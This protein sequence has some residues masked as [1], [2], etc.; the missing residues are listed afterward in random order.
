MVERITDSE[1]GKRVINVVCTSLSLK[2]ESVV[3]ITENS[4]LVDDLGA[5]SLDVVE[6]VMAFET[7]FSIE[8]SDEDAQKIET[9]GDAV[10][11][12]TAKVEA[13]SQA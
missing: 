10:R 8:I 9:I 13:M 6:M 7:E 3:S 4:K 12:V 2:S 1:I 5:D 11:Y